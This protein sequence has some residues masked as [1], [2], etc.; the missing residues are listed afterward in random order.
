MDRC[1]TGCLDCLGTNQQDL[2]DGIKNNKTFK[3]ETRSLRE[4]DLKKNCI[5]KVPELQ[6]P[7][8]TETHVPA[9]PLEV[10]LK[11]GCGGK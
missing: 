4:T 10:Q 3:K 2:N 5:P 7:P 6:Q 8:E 1:S 11:Y 9:K